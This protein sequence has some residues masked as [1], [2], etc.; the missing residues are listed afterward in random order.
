MS[1][2]GLI[3][4]AASKSPIARSALPLRGFGQA[5]IVVGESEFRIE[6]D[7]LV[8]ILNGAVVVALL[9]IGKAAVV[10]GDRELG[11]EL[12]GLV[13]ILNGAVEVALVAER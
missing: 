11:I 3:L 7:G 8:E 10:V 6:P 13:E 2:C 1:K 9:V 4:I 12:D 5:A